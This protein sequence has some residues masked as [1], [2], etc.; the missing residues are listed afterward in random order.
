MNKIMMYTDIDIVKY[1]GRKRANRTEFNMN[2]LS[3]L[4]YNIL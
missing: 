2:P 3:D 1:A 4:L